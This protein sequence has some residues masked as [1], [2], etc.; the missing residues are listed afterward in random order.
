MPYVGDGAALDKRR[1]VG[2][3]G[4]WNKRRGRGNVGRSTGSA[5]RHRRIL[6]QL[7]GGRVEN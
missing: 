6:D 7:V 4:G 3:F 5:E 2:G 1:L